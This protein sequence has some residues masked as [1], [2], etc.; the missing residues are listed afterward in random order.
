MMSYKIYDLITLPFLS[1]HNAPNS[2]KY[3]V[4]FGDINSWRNLADSGHSKDI[5][6]NENDLQE[7]IKSVI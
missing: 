5:V 1:P 4:A 6:K 3:N 7:R 2:K